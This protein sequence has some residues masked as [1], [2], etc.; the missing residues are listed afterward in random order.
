MHVAK[1]PY[2][3]QDII[4]SVLE[5]VRGRDYSFHLAHL[6]GNESV[7][8]KVEV[9]G[10]VVRIVCKDYLSMELAADLKKLVEEIEKAS[11]W[12]HGYSNRY[13][14]EL[15]Y[16]ETRF[17]IETPTN[18]VPECLRPLLRNL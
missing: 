18:E 15:V 14:V 13:E 4:R 11:E 10:R 6:S 3:I 7:A 16:Y 5:E 2:P 12:A 1:K 17:S 8:V 9:R